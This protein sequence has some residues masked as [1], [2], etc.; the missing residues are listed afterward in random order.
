MNNKKIEFKIKIQIPSQSA[1]P[2]PP[3]GPIL[4]QKGINI[5]KFCKE[6][7][8]KTINIEKGLIIPTIINIYKDKTYFFILKNPPVSILLKKK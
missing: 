3:I 5:V 6:F 4:G 7:N 8:D 2:S 1:N